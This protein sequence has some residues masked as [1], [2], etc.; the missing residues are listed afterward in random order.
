ML[1]IAVPRTGADWLTV[2]GVRLML[3]DGRH[4]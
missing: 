1:L 2:A 4:A 3:A